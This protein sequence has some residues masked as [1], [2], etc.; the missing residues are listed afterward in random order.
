MMNCFKISKN[1]LQI[2]NKSQQL[3]FP[4]F[5]QF[6]FYLYQKRDKFK[7]LCKLAKSNWQ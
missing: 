7:H 5:K 3:K 6:K 4:N 1:N 2:T